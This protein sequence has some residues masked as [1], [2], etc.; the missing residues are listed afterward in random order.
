MDLIM[1]SHIII[2]VFLT[3]TALAAVFLED[4]FASVI[5]YSAYSFCM[6]LTYLILRSSEIA[7]TEAAIGAGLTT[8]LFVAALAKTSR[9]EEDKE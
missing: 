5:V 9:K 7:M 2:L 6:C 8:M 1:V 3:V 4:L